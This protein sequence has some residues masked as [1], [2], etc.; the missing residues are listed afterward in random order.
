MRHRLHTIIGLAALAAV[1]TTSTPPPATATVDGAVETLT[2]TV[3][4][5]LGV[6]TDWLA[7]HGHRGRGYVGEVGWPDD[8]RWERVARAWY[9][10]ADR[11][12]LWV[13]A[14]AAGP[15]WG[16]Y[17]LAVFDV[18]GRPNAQAEVVLDQAPRKRSVS[19]AGAE[20]GTPGP[21]QTW[22]P[23]F[24]STRPGA[25]G[26]D[27]THPPAA[28]LR[29]LATAGITT[30]RLPLRW[31]RLQ[32]RLGGTLA[33]A[34]A[35][36]LHTT[37]D[38]ADAAGLEVILDLHNY[39]AYWAGAPWGDGYRKPIGGGYVTVGHFADLWMRLASEYRGHPAL[40]GYGL[41][42]EPVALPGGAATWED[43]SQ[44]AVDAIRQVDTSTRVFVSG[45]YYGATW[46][47]PVHHP[48]GPW[49]DDPT[50]RTWYE[51]H[52]YFDCDHSGTYPVSID[53]VAAC[54]DG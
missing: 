21:T 31:E 2:R 16:D 14:W 7:E 17:P 10:A 39:G 18:A 11:E 5:D 38:A 46:A 52:H 48:A 51:A 50:G 37:L 43:A 36:R 25:H 49:I 13:S 9:A 35:D 41:M 6:F 42:N 32:P 23:R 26:V 54:V 3:V 33:A 24:S 8:P 29:A 40:V 45:Y 22:S 28:L 47:F 30:I 1:L 20:F 34:E 4:E 44:A 12:W 19:V 15:W 53:E 27:Y